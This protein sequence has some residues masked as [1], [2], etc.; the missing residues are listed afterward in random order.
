[1]GTWSRAAKGVA[2]A[3]VVLA[4][5]FVVALAA[6]SVP[7]R[8]VEDPILDVAWRPSFD[9][10]TI[11]A[12]LVVIAF[13][14]GAVILILSAKQRGPRSE[15][16]RRHGL[17]VLVLGILVFAIVARLM[18]SI[19][20]TLVPETSEVIGEVVEQPFAQ[21]S[22]NAIWLLSLLVA[23][24]VAIA[25]TRVGLAIRSGAPPIEDAP[26]PE[27]PALVAGDHV[28]AVDH[29]DDPRGRV[30]RAYAHFEQA[31]DEVG[32]I[33]APAETAA[34]HVA[35]AKATFDL[36]TRD[37]AVLSSRHAQARFG[38]HE[39]TLDEAMEAESASDRLRDKVRR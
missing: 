39:P 1:M 30:F 18:R 26:P 7:G 19:S 25:L 32:V 13:V 4:L 36:G 16:R 8:G 17:A 20:G 2:S 15:R 14:T 24:V 22:G 34:H 27:T 21:D 6:N 11:L 10:T 38:D 37:V 5:G 33:R 31:L 3:L 29:G 35:R 9:L 28:S 12:W 23:A